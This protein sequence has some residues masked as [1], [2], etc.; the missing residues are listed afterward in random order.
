LSVGMGLS[1]SG[2]VR[3]NHRTGLYGCP[4]ARRVPSIRHLCRLA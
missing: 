1:A 2:M 4:P 3:E